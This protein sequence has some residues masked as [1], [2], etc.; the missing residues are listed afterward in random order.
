MA[1][2]LGVMSYDIGHLVNGEIQKLGNGEHAHA[3]IV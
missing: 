3:G 2:S 1:S